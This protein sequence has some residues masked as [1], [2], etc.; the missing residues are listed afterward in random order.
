MEEIWL[1]VD[2]EGISPLM[3]QKLVSMGCLDVREGNVQV[4]NLRNIVRMNRLR[5]HL[6][7]NLAGAAVILEILDRLEA[8]ER[9]NERLRRRLEF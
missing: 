3:L 1:P 9:E 7:V 2:R 5:R 4:E 8:M 6:G